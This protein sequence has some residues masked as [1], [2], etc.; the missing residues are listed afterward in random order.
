MPPFYFV[1]QK[2][3]GLGI[4]FPKASSIAK[5]SSVDSFIA[6]NERLTRNNPTHVFHNYLI[7]RAINILLI[8]T[9][10]DYFYSVFT[11]LDKEAIGNSS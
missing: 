10:P 11:L 8:P 3:R 5:T 6:D 7:N 2:L 1:T 4:S 9:M